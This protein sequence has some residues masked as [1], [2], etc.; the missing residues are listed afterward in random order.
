MASRPDAITYALTRDSAIPLYRQIMSRV[1]GDIAS[2]QLPPG[3][4]LGSE[5]ELS[6]LFGVSRITI[7]QALQELVTVGL[8]VR[9]PGKGTF[10]RAD[11]RALRLTRLTG[12]G[13]NMRQIGRVPGYRTLTVE[14]IAAPA[15]VA[16]SLALV[17][18]TLV[19]RIERVLLADGEPI[20][21]QN[22]YLPI[23]LIRPALPMLTPALLDSAS[24]YG[25]LEDTTGLV[26]DRAVEEV[27]PA[28][29]GAREAE[30]LETPEGTLLLRVHRVVFDQRDRGIEDV[31]LHYHA[32]RYSFRV[33][34]D[35]RHSYASA[36]VRLSKKAD[37]QKEAAP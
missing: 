29:A 23:Q 15:R 24:L 16:D 12:F 20:A 22:S 14:Q 10:V 21:I 31:I 28:V 18:H 2:G 25:V 33:E 6:R 3:S 7:R 9:T 26:L 35:R 17:S 34:L 8:L 37:E 32:G 4:R 1:E 30:I 11:T 5:S 36:G 13:E 19:V 27:D